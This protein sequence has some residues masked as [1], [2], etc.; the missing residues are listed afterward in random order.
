MSWV[1]K[2]TFTATTPHA[3]SRAIPASYS[4]RGLRSTARRRASSP[5]ALA[6]VGSPSTSTSAEARASTVLG[7]HQAAALPV[8]DQLGHATD[9]GGHRRAG[10]GH[11]LDHD[12]GE[13]LQARR[14]DQARGLVDDGPHLVTHHVTDE[15]HA[16]VQPVGPGSFLELGR[17]GARTGQ[18]EARPGTRRRTCYSTHDS[19]S[20]STA[21]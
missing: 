3:A 5:M 18:R 21:L 7:W 4:S 10:P 6:L 11:G 20:T 17:L 13:A 12:A 14:E 19:S 9:G 15:P 8:V 16:A 1:T 2:M